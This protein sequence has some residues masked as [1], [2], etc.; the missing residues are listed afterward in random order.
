MVRSFP[1]PYNGRRARLH[2]P[3]DEE[4]SLRSGG[5]NILYVKDDKTRA[6]AN[7]ILLREDLI[8]KG[9]D[10]W[11]VFAIDRF[12]VTDFERN[13]NLRRAIVQEVR[14]H[15]ESLGDVDKANVV[16][17]IPERALFAQDQ[18]PVTAS[19]I[20]YPRPAA[21]SRPTAKSWRAS[22]RSSSSRWP[23]S[24]PKTS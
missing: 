24:R 7:A 20:L 16:L 15:I 5:R 23:A 18:N 9:T 6:Q 4:I 19:V 11:S 3:P 17:E 2:Q 13:V 21:T 22:R 8:P 14:R 12:T 10:P 1:P